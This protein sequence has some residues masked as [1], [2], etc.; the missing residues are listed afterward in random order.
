MTRF[1]SHYST[2]IP[3]GDPLWAEFVEYAIALFSYACAYVLMV[4]VA[5]WE[6]KRDTGRDK[7]AVRD[8]MAMPDAEQEGFQAVVDRGRGQFPARRVAPAILNIARVD[9]LV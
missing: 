6:D 3:T 1:I 4:G 2:F 7:N 5:K 8:R 9:G